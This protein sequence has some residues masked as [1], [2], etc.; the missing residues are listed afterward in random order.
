MREQAKIRFYYSKSL[1]FK[2]DLEDPENLI[3][4]E[5]TQVRIDPK[6]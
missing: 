1:G 4:L 3:S 2:R 5:F 6:I